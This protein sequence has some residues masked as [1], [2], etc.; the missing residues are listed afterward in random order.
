MKRFLANNP[1]TGLEFQIKDT[2]SYVP[3]VTL[4]K[5]NDTM[6]LENLKS[7]FKKT[8]KW[9]KYRSQ[10]T[11]QN[12]NNNLNYLIDPTFTSVNTLFVLSFERI[13]ENNV[14][15]DYR[16]SFSHYYVPNIQIKDY[17]VLIDGKSFFN[18]P[19]KN[20]EEAYEKIIKMSNNVDYTTG[21]LLD[22]AYFKENCRLI[23]TDLSKQT[24]INDP[25]Q[26]NFIGKIENENNG[27]TIFFIIQRTEKTTFEF[28]QN[29]VNIL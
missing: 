25:Q 14:K 22:F 16:D 20:E 15:K 8:I 1:P 26:I 29:S 17:N 27:E 2:K 9:N 19:V 12:N 24:K 13:E 4:S 5:E 28:S 23:A 7:G 18:L 3:V 11:I 21:N 10:M 6:L